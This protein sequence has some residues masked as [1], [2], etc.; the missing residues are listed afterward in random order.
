[1][2]RKDSGWDGSLLVITVQLSML[3]SERFADNDGR[4]V[5][6]FTLKMLSLVSC[7]DQPAFLRTPGCVDC[8]IS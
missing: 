3:K 2:Q 5:E 6:I 4:E 7:Q 8:P 1:M